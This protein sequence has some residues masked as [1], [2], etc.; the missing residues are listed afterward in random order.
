MRA[1]LGGELYVESECGGKEREVNNLDFNKTSKAL[2]YK[3]FTR[4]CQESFT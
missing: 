4:V 1:S 2:S 3:L